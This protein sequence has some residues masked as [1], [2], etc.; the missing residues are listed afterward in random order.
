MV[1]I[2][3]FTI[4]GFIIDVFVNGIVKVFNYLF[5]GID[6]LTVE[7]SGKVFVASVGW[8]FS[9]WLIGKFIEKFEFY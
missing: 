1:L 2:S 9:K 6:I 5:Y 8:V 7:G 4:E 3:E